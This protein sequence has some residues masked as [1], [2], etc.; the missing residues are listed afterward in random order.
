MCGTDH[1]HVRGIPQLAAPGRITGVVA[2]V[3]Q[4]DPAT[5]VAAYDLAASL[6]PA[7]AEQVTAP[8]ALP[9]LTLTQCALRDAPRERVRAFVTRLEDML[10]GAVIPLSAVRPFGAGFLF[11]CA[12]GDGAGR[13]AL[14]A[15]H[16]HAVTL[17][18]GLLDPVAND[19]V[20]EATA[21]AFA[22]DPVLVGN[23]R[24]HGYALVRERYL[25]HI[26]LGFDPRLGAGRPAGSP[27]AHRPHA[28]TMDRVVLAPL[29]RYGRVEATFAV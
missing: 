2:L 3:L 4:P 12:E 26:T 17:A 25:P 24:R 15:A 14:Q 22:D 18:D 20:V 1:P 19:A 23:A 5:I 10:R 9:H 7:A 28:M 27:V 8:G 16:E 21:R 6:M 13:R 29:G 11:W